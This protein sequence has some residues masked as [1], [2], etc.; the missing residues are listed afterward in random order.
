MDGSLTGEAQS[1]IWSG[2]LTPSF[3]TYRRF[4]LRGKGGKANKTYWE[5]LLFPVPYE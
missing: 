4:L 5:G 3:A 1:L 2:F